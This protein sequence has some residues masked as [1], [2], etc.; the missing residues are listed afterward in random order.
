MR[1]IF[2][3]NECSAPLSRN[4]SFSGR[5]LTRWRGGSGAARRAKVG[6]RPIADLRCRQ[7]DVRSWPGAEWLLS[8]AQ[9]G[10][11]DDPS[12]FGFG[13]FRPGADVRWSGRAA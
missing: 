11:A 3:L 13:R 1:C 2:R 6:L 10:K 7:S 4:R 9:G 12:M 5:R 8:G